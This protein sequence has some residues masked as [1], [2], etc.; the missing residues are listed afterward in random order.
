[1]RRRS[2]NE[3]ATAASERLQRLGNI[4]LTTGYGNSLG[5]YGSYGGVGTYGK[6]SIDL[7]G[8]V[9]GAIIGIGSLLI[10]PKILN[11]FSGHT[12]SSGGYYRS[13]CSFP[14]P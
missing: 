11:V 9:L 7:G 12:S 14:L 5:G 2:I 4:G 8:V 1:M 3:T 13:M 6:P 10:L